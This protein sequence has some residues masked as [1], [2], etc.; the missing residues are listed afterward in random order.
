[1]LCVAPGGIAVVAA[2]APRIRWGGRAPP[3]G[4]VPCRSGPWFDRS[5]LFAFRRR[6]ECRSS[7]D[8][9]ES[10]AQLADGP[11]H[12]GVLSRRNKPKQRPSPPAAEALPIKTGGH[13][14][15]QHTGDAMP[16]RWIGYF[17]AFGCGFAISLRA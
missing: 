12:R 1:M 11:D 5:L 17:F 13:P 3:R 9:I 6:R 16:T 7:P 2:R 15:D 8:L 4:I 10:L 14:R